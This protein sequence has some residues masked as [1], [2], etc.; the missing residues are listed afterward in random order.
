[1]QGNIKSNANNKTN[2]TDNTASVNINAD[3]YDHSN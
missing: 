3:I 2:I 1:M